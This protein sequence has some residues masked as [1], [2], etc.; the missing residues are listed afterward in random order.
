LVVDAGR[1]AKTALR[2]SALLAAAQRGRAEHDPLTSTA[3]S[4]ALMRISLDQR[5]VNRAGDILVGRNRIGRRLLVGWRRPDASHRPRL[6]V[7][8][9][10]GSGDPEH[11]RGPGILR[12]YRAA[13]DRAVTPRVKV[14]NQASSGILLCQ[15][16]WTDASGSQVASYCDAAG[17]YDAGVFVYDDG[18]FAPNGMQVPLS[19]EIPA[20]VSEPSQ[21]GPLNAW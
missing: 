8:R 19:D 11:G 6:G 15:A 21:E 4:I 16:L 10:V 9:H 2:A 12:R 17:A 3:L 20:D 1:R 18:H 5:Q 13:A 7:L 14:A